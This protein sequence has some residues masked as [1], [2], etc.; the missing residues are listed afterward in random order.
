MVTNPFGHQ[1]SAQFKVRFKKTFG[2]YPEPKHTAFGR[3][4]RMGRVFEFVENGRNIQ[5]V[6]DLAKFEDGSG[7]ELEEDDHDPGTTV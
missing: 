2:F 4:H 7:D 3:A 5:E 1:G 6:G